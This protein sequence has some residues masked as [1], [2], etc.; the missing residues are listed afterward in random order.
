MD[1]R[2]RTAALLD[3]NFVSNKVSCVA[4]DVD[5]THASCSND[6]SLR[7]EAAFAFTLLVASRVYVSIRWLTSRETA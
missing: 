3:R 5:F 6:S 7:H 2:L 1:P 4:A